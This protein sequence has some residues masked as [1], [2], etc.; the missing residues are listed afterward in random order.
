MKKRI[1][2][3]IIGQVERNCFFRVGKAMLRVEFAGGAVNSSGIYPALYVTDNPLYQSVIEASDDFK[4]GVIKRG[5]VEEIS[6]E[7]DEVKDGESN[8]SVYPEVTTLQQARQLLIAEPYCCS[9]ASLQ[10][11]VAVKEAAKE[12]NVKFPN[13]I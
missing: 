5:N 10:N 8:D 13:W 6:Q 12:K 7:N 2:Y 1:T 4:R 9:M 11:K 3:E